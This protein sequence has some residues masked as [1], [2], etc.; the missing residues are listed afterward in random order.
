MHLLLALSTGF[1]QAAE[2]TEVD[3]PF[4]LYTSTLDN[5]LVV[6]LQPRDGATSLHGTLVVGS[7]GRY[8]TLETSGS[9]HLLEHL[10]F[11]RTELWDERQVSEWIED[12]GGTYNGTT[13]DRTVQYWAWVGPDDLDPLLLWLEQIVFHPVLEQDQLEK[14]REI[15]FEE[16][17]GRDGWWMG[18]V[19]ARGFGR[20]MWEAM[21]LHYWPDS[22]LSVPR[23]GK[24]SSLDAITLPQLQDFYDA[25]YRVDNTALVLVGAMDPEQALAAVEA[26]IG[27]LGG[28]AAFEDVAEAGPPRTPAPSRETIYRLG[29]FDQWEVG[30]SSP[31]HGSGHPDH[32][33]E[34]MASAYLRDLMFERLRTDRALVYGVDSGVQTWVDAGHLRVTTELDHAKV[35]EVLELIQLTLDEAQTVDPDRLARVRAQM[36]GGSQRR[37]EDTKSRSSLLTHAWLTGVRLDPA[38]RWS[39]SLEEVE[40]AIGSWDASTRT[41]WVR[42]AVWT[43]G[44]AWQLGGVAAILAL[45]LIWMGIRR[46]RRTP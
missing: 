20:S 40:R 16:R 22:M 5:G 26:G 44:Q 6:W 11:T 15:V 9:S 7:G 1:A 35:D 41:E 21:A 3:A 27:Q 29:I 37:L 36:I 4:P 46:W 25:H 28:A 14:E 18:E 24:D 43:V 45:G 38:E 17:G 23:I 34:V 30:V 42:R 19:R 10:L 2:L 31:A 33:A 13:Y 39:A 12:L 32:D 8:E